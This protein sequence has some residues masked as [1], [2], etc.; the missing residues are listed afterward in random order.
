MEGDVT[1]MGVEEFKRLASH[2]KDDRLPSRSN[3][4]SKRLRN[5]NNERAVGKVLE[6]FF[7]KAGLDVSKLDSLLAQDQAELRSAFQRQIA[8]L[9]KHSRFAEVTF[10]QRIEARRKALRILENP[11]TST[12]IALDTPFVIWEYP[13]PQFGDVLVDTH[14]EAYNNWAKIKMG[15]DGG[16]SDN[17]WFSFAFPWTNESDDD[18]V[19]NITSSLVLNGT[20]LAHAA[21]G[22]FSG[23]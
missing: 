23:D 19:I 15:A 6:S 8:D 12:F 7:T 3:F 14:Y 20:C 11:F 1:R 2:E 13:H 9:T 4:S 22:V 10:R 16:G 21:G 17:R 18:V 5:R